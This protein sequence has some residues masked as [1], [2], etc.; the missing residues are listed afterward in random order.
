MLLVFF[1]R[2]IFVIIQMKT[3]FPASE[4]KPNWV[5]MILNTRFL[6]VLSMILGNGD[7]SLY[8]NETKNE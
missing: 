4:H 6:P 5:L 1:V 2:N 8:F 3:I 7:F